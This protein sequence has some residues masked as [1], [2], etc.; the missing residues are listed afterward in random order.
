MN[1]NNCVISLKGILLSIL[2]S[3]ALLS[4]G[5][6]RGEAYLVKDG[7]PCADIVISDKPARAVKLASTELQTYL[8]KIS[9]AKLAITNTPG[10][11][12][13]AHI[14]VGR[15]AETD[16][17]KITDEGLKGGAFRMLSG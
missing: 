10:A 15:S 4:A 11:D 8:E 3:I 12:V 2:G 16:K 14:Y 6:V 17:L 5:S 9:G 1:K 13:P 7:K